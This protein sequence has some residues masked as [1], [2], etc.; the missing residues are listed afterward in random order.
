MGLEVRRKG[1]GDFPA[2]WNDNREFRSLFS[3]IEGRTVVTEDRCFMLYQL[4]RHA[5]QK[6]GEIAEIGVYKGGTGKLIARSCPDKEVHLFDTFSGMP[7]TD[8]S[9]DHHAEGDFFDTSLESV[10]EF[11]KEC[12]NVVFHPGFFPDTADAV[13]DRQFCFVYI[14]VDIY[15]SV[16]DS[17][18]F[19]YDKLVQGGIIVID[20]YEFVVCP[21]VKKAIDEFLID[22]EEVPIVTANY[23]CML[24]KL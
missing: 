14:D 4:V 7:K 15:Q 24:I 3:E 11:L 5:S 1:R 13:R 8:A 9:E 16:K 21:G 19:F 10:Q 6:E 23:Q 18:E 17:L 20:D 2:F 22:K 12:T